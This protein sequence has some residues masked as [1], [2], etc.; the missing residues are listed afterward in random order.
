[1]MRWTYEPDEG[2]S[3]AGGELRIVRRFLWFPKTLPSV[4]T[5]GRFY[6]GEWRGDVQ[7]RW[8]EFAEIV[9]WFLISSDGSHFVSE[10]W[11]DAEAKKA[12][13]RQE[14]WKRDPTSIWYRGPSEKRA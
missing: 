6:R 14:S 9:Q 8:L 11:L 3:P 7:K 10:S 5:D 1:M 2:R 4:H 12:Y 13:D